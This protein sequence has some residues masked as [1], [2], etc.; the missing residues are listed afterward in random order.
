MTHPYFFSPRKVPSRTCPEQ[1]RRNDLFAVFRLAEHYS[2]EN[3]YRSFR[4]ARK[5]KRD[6]G[7]VIYYGPYFSGKMICRVKPPGQ[8]SRDGYL[9]LACN[10]WYHDFIVPTNLISPTILDAKGSKWGECNLF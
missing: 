8:R 10:S 6:R 1:S 4:A 5:G 9:I 3:L 7:V 2:F